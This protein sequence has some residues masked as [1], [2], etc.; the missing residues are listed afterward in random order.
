MVKKT[1]ATFL[2]LA[3]IVCRAQEAKQRYKTVQAGDNS[4]NV[5]YGVNTILLFHSELISWSATNKEVKP[6]GPVGLMCEHLVNDVV[7]LGL[8]AG[9][10]KVTVDYDGEGDL[11]NPGSL[12]HYTI[13]FTSVRVMFRANF[14]FALS[15]HFNAYGLVSAGYRSLKWNYSSSDPNAAEK[16][17]YN[18]TFPFGFKPGFGLR[19]FFNDN[20]GLNLEV[21]TGTPVLSGGL[22][23]KF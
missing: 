15:N 5:Y 1:L 16:L 8:E 20:I 7:G 14:H 2:A 3:M 21:A 10:S 17:A 23:L 9:Y 11:S 22:T 12:Y 6:F 4:I 19:Y 18:S 13:N